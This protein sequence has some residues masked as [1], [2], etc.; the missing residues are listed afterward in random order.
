[1]EAL[2][3]ELGFEA[4]KFLVESFMQQL[5]EQEHLIRDAADEVKQLDKDLKFLKDFVKES[6]HM[7]NRDNLIT[8]TLLK[9]VRDSIYEAED[10]IDSYVSEAAASGS[11]ACFS[12]AIP[13][14][15]LAK[16]AQ[17]VKSVC[18]KLA[19]IR[20]EVKD[21]VE[22]TGGYT[23]SELPD[24]RQGIPE[25]PK[26]GPIFKDEEKKLRESLSEAAQ[27]LEVI[28]I[29]G[30]HG[31]GKTTL[32]AKM[33]Y[34]S[35]T[36]TNFDKRIWIS[37]SNKTT[38]NI[39]LSILRQLNKLPDQDASSGDDQELSRL[40]SHCLQHEKLLIVADHVQEIEDWQKLES[41]LKSRNK[42]SKVLVTTINNEVARY[43]GQY[44]PIELKPLS[45]KE[46]WSLLEWRVSQNSGCPD[47]LVED[48]KLIAEQC[49]GLP[50][51]IEFAG[52]TLA[53]IDSKAYDMS[54]RRKIWQDV[55]LDMGTYFND[56]QMMNTNTNTSILSSYNNLPYQMRA[57]FL[58][59]SIFP[60]HSTFSVSKLIR[61]WIAEG[62]IQPSDGERVA[63]KYL[64]HLIDRNLVIVEHK[65][66]DGSFKTCRMNYLLYDFCKIE[67]GN[68]RENF[69]QEFKSSNKDGA[70]TPQI[71]EV[72]K[73][74][75]VCIHAQISKFIP[76]FISSRPRSLDARLR[77]FVS[78]SDKE[79]F[80]LHGRDI[81]IIRAAFK[82]LRVLD[83]KPIEFN[84]IPTDMWQ[85]VHL[86][87]VTLSL[88]KAV[89]PSSISKL[90]NIQTLVVHTTSQTLT[91]KADILKMSELR[92]FK[93]NASATLPK[94]SKAC[95]EDERL[96]ALCGISPKSCTEDFFNKTPNLKKL[97]IHG[98]LALLLLDDK[99]ELLRKLNR[100]EKLKLLNA[101]TSP[102][103]EGQLGTLLQ[104]SRFPPRL[105]SLTLS[106]TCLDWKHISV[107]GSIKNLEE[108]KLKDNAF[109][110]DKWEVNNEGFPNLQT[111]QIESLYFK[112]WKSL[113]NH[114]PQ[115]RRLMLSRC[116]ELREI[117]IGLAHIR[118]FRELHLCGCNKYAAESAQSI[119]QIKLK[120]KLIDSNNV[121]KL[122][123]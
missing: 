40:V 39:H 42:E 8:R 92:H 74:R 84:K 68:E 63:E 70:F 6:A 72:E 104:P 75:R 102:K 116:K 77:S 18:G 100:L 83:A 50:S 54:E 51:V 85:L 4:L 16:I 57:C 67:A 7:P 23:R 53:R 105:R 94:K 1:M 32:A 97:G 59:L 38:R 110:G 55:C 35:D 117:P 25:E 114:F 71:N 115:L 52:Y 64:K 109:V 31:I 106:A 47:V 15:K 36:Q 34:D 95:E 27:Q 91:I 80:A 41:T 29:T 81:S 46:S 101:V 43:I 120:M 49:E 107:L 24:Q 108:L 21:Y 69:I 87:Y 11:T 119:L 28:I 19:T 113:S 123:I 99:N 89:L 45:S 44:N 96:Q 66:P 56:N 121:F 73:N 79:V 9:D 62:F 26:F 58:Y 82:L 12:G 48:G 13:K 98:Q 65:R 112:H 122:L 37:V 20:A 5:N 76:K 22:K 86:R 2:A 88:N 10:T 118:T 93:T 111:L 3:L 61:M 90:R 33:F 60:R 78:H 30:T 103:T 17:V 14:S